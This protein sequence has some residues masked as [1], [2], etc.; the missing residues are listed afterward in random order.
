VVAGCD[1]AHRFADHVAVGDDVARGLRRRSRN[2]IRELIA[3]DLDVAEKR[4][5]GGLAFLVRGTMAV[6]ASGEGGLMVRVD[7]AQTDALLTKPHAG[8]SSWAAARCR[9]GYESTP[10]ACGPSA[11]LSAG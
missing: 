9:A 2:R 10:T 5:F 7:P 8:R 4:M 6:A 3:A 11:S 1:V